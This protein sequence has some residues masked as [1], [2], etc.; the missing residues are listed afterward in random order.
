MG[1]VH[2]NQEKYNH[3]TNEIQAAIGKLDKMVFQVLDVM[4]CEESH[5][6]QFAAASARRSEPKS[7]NG[8]LRGSFCG[9]PSVP[10]LSLPMNL[11]MEKTSPRIVFESPRTCGLS[12]G[13]NCG[14]E[15]ILKTNTLPGTK[16]TPELWKRIY[17]RNQAV[18]QVGAK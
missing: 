15:K 3:G 16:E 8:P 11:N 17:A 6:T 18:T 10:R 9:T 12:A 2:E 14:E 13:G 1:E 5:S 7:E 4:K